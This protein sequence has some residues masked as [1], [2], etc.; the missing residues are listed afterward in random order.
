MAVRVDIRHLMGDNEMVLGI[1]FSLH[2]VA[3]DTGVLAP[4]TTRAWRWCWS[5]SS[6]CIAAANRCAHGRGAGQHDLRA[7]AIHYR[8]AGDTARLNDLRPYEHRWAAGETVIKLGATRDL[9][10]L[11][12]PLQQQ[13]PSSDQRLAVYIGSLAV[14]N[15]KLAAELDM[16]KRMIAQL[17]ADLEKAKAQTDGK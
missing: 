5:P 11:G 3:D 13:P 16:A 7:S 8:V 10:L 6:F 4:A 9:R 17:Q 15:A 1:D 14:E 12:Q 2:V